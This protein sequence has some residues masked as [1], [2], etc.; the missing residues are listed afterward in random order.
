MKLNIGSGNIRFDDFLNVDINP[1]FADIVHD[2]RKI[3]YP[4]DDNTIDKIIASHI[5]EHLYVDEHL[6]FMDECWRIL[7]PEGCMEIIFPMW[8]T[9]SAWIDPTHV[10]AIHP[11][12]YKYFTTEME[13]MGY[14][15]KLWTIVSTKLVDDSCGIMLRPIKNKIEVNYG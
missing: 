5:V 11:D 3:P 1:L 10:R 8:N 6:S 2:L 15:T 7:Q 13:G 4:F 14:T 9:A 12:Q